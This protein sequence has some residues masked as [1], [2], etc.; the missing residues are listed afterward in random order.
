MAE[1]GSD[2]EATSNYYRPW[3]LEKKEERYSTLNRIFNYEKIYQVVQYKLPPWTSRDLEQFAKENPQ[4][5]ENVS[6]F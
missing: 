4:D 2:K 6:Q 1:Q 5:G 3:W